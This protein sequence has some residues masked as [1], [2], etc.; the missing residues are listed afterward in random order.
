MRQ[1][2]G[3]EVGEIGIILI[4]ACSTFKPPCLCPEGLGVD[5]IITR[6]FAGLQSGLE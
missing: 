3:G 5:S 2:A 4:L 6:L 1:L